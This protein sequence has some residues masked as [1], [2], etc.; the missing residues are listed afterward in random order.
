MFT[1]FFNI[2][3]NTADR[4]QSQIHLSQ[5]LIQ[6]HNAFIN[7]VD[8][9]FCRCKVLLDLIHGLGGFG[10]GLIDGS[11]NCSLS[12]ADC[13][14]HPPN[15]GRSYDLDC[16]AAFI[17]S[18]QVPSSPSHAHGE[19]LSEAEQRGQTIFD[20]PALG[21]ITCHPPPL[22]TDQLM[23]DVGTATA[24]ERIGPA[25]DTPS[26]RGLYDS[27]PY[28]HDGSASTLRDTLN[29]PSSGNEHDVRG[30]L[31]E[32]EIGDLIDFLIALPFE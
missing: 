12:P 10:S 31:T 11:M 25:Y 8:H 20:D 15:Q 5:N 1:P 18:L 21:C 6:P 19:P 13:V 2:F 9:F 16:L 29:R 17:D 3:K 26:L 23:H 7:T 24:N 30:L 28:F 22:Y 32:D 14:N 27:A 4:V